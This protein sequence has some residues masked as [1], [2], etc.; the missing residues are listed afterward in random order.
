[1]FEQVIFA[2]ATL[3]GHRVRRVLL[4]SVVPPMLVATASFPSVANAATRGFK[5]YNLSS[6]AIKFLG[7]SG[8]DFDGTP[9][10]GSILQPGAPYQDFEET[11]KFGQTTTGVAKYAVLDANGNPTGTNFF[12]TMQIYNVNTTYAAAGTSA[13]EGQPPI[14]LQGSTN[15]V[16][17]N[18]LLDPA[19]TVHNI[20]AG[21]GQAQAAVLNQFC[22]DGNSATCDFTVTSE[23]HFEGAQHFIT[24]YANHDK[25]ITNDYTYNQGDE[26]GS[27]NSVEVA[28][29]AGGKLFKIVDAEISVTYNHTW[30]ETHSFSTSVTVHCPPVS[31]CSIYGIA[32]M[33]RD[34]G[35][36]KLTLGNTTWN[37]PDVYFD[38]P[39]PS[40]VESFAS[41]TEPLTAKQLKT[42]PFG[43]VRSATEPY[44]TPSGAPIVRSRLHLTVAGPRIV[45][46]G[47]RASYRITLSRK[48]SNHELVYTPSNIRVVSTQA[49]HRVGRWRLSTLS[50]GTA[51]TLILH[52]RVSPKARRSFCL[53]TAAA[54]RDTRSAR[55][56]VCAAV[57]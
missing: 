33:L 31:L 24:S 14:Y 17:T 45:A 27:S 30:T 38:S 18:T 34:T 20:P 6:Y 26:V 48:Q 40:K 36:F 29:K 42:L 32:P 57:A 53:V 21:Q 7:V 39:E 15:G 22:V 35:N 13:T 43:H 10:V 5:V 54:G 23:K 19:G 50:P 11:Y 9:P 3:G 28:V 12:A 2:V 49:G 44:R 1:M 41:T 56:R 37:L 46:A 55:T 52:L 16:D 51:R 25:N 8:A 4:A 47:D